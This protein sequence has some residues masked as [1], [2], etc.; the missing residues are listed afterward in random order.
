M[1]YHDH[2][3]YKTSWSTN[4]TEEES[5]RKLPRIQIISPQK[6]LYDIRMLISDKEAVGRMSTEELATEIA[7]II[8]YQKAD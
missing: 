3:R 6:Q 1:S 7:Q 4:E 8:N 5:T 2:G